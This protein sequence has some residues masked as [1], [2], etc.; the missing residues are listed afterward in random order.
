[1]QLTVQYIYQKS[2]GRGEE[3]SFFLGTRQFWNSCLLLWSSLPFPLPQA[4]L[5][6]LW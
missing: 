1:L 6:C 3:K 5:L 4:Q 2:G